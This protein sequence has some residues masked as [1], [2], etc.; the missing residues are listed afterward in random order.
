[1]WRAAWL[2]LAAA[3]LA[4]GGAG[5][6]APKAKGKPTFKGLLQQDKGRGPAQ[7]LLAP[8]RRCVAVGCRAGA[9]AAAAPAAPPLKR[10]KAYAYSQ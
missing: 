5:R 2:D 7:R 1:M 3:A 6:G 8:G 9:R 4:A 10:P